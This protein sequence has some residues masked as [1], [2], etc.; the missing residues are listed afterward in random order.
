MKL[1]KINFFNYA[2]EGFRQSLVFTFQSF[3]EFD[4]LVFANFIRRILLHDILCFILGL[5]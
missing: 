5:G 3:V 1:L 2:C 4:S